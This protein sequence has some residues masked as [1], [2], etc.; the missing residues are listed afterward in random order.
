MK[1]ELYVIIKYYNYVFLIFVIYIL[2]NKNNYY[3]LFFY[4]LMINIVDFSYRC[5][6]VVN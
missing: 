1:Y 3:C 4:V 6:K 5:G 2:L